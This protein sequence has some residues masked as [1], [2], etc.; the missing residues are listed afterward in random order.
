MFDS[1]DHSL[2][3]Y[4]LSH[5][6]GI[7]GP[8]LALLSSYFN[9]CVQRVMLD[10]SFSHWISV[11]FGVLQ[12]SSLGPL[13]FMLYL[14]D[15]QDSIVNGSRVLIYVDNYKLLKAISNVADAKKLQEDINCLANCSNKWNLRI[16]P[17][18]TV[19]MKF[20]KIKRKVHI[21]SE[22]N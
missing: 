7:H 18:K 21:S 9:N 11:T 19:A 4:K 6:F 8:L 17:S 20:T 1:V 12:G 13:C 10:G 14:D 22:K 2:M 5:R 3:L 16:N 15:L